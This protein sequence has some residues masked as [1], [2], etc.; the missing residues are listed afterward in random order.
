MAKGSGLDNDVI[1]RNVVV[2][3]PGAGF[4][5][6]HRG[7]SP[8]GVPLAWPGFAA[9]G[10]RRSMP[11]V[12]PRAVADTHHEAVLVSCVVENGKVAWVQVVSKRRGACN[13]RIYFDVNVPQRQ[14][15]VPE[16]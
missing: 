13:V 8:R 10:H 2:L 9:V 4:S 15:R 6:R 14:Q 3:P 16:L 1:A 7:R 5:G 11:L 12:A